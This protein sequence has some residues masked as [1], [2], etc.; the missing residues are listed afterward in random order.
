MRA[1]I[2]AEVV[3]RPIRQVAAPVARN[4]YLPPQFAAAFE[5][6]HPLARLGGDN[7]RYHPGGP[8]ANHYAIP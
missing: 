5:Q 4:Q 1:V 2:V 8:T 7:G 3:R 6:G